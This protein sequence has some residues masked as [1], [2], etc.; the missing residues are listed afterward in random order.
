MPV[1]P[2]RPQAGTLIAFDY[3]LKNIGSAI[4]E[5]QF[6]S[7][8]EHK[9]FKARDGVPNWQEIGALLAQ[10]QPVRVLV[11]KPLNMDGTESE[12]SRRAAKFA[13]RLQGRFGVVVELVD[14]RLSS[15]EAKAEAAQ[16]QHRGR[17]ADNPIDAIAARII[18]QTWYQLR[19]DASAHTP[20]NRGI[21]DDN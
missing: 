8:S 11:G 1:T 6:E 21:Q 19:R 3:G 4:G 10:W 16:R 5:A 7:A 13:N 2:E 17:Y 9:V 18:L 20:P 12:L 15:R 14:E